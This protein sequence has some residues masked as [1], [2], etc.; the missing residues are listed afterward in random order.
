MNNH[1]KFI[2]KTYRESIKNI[3]QKMGIHPNTL[4]NWENGISKPNKKMFNKLITKYENFEII[5]LIDEGNCELLAQ[6]LKKIRKNH[7]LTQQELADK[8]QI[9]ISTVRS[10]EHRV[11]P[12]RQGT[13]DYIE[14]K[15]YELE[16]VGGYIEN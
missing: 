1:F 13:L 2:R 14:P 15:V 11:Y 4:Y 16:K 5:K 9:G 3:S 10:I 6:R 12:P 7:S 8:L